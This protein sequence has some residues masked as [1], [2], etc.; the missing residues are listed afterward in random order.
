MFLLKFDSDVPSVGIKKSNA[1][2]TEDLLFPF[3][4]FVVHVLVTMSSSKICLGKGWYVPIM[5]W[6]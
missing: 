4:G 3:V 5:K 2:D 1:Y 6:G